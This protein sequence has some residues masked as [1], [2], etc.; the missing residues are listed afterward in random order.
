MFVYKTLKK[1]SVDYAQNIALEDPKRSINYQALHQ[2]SL[3]IAE[4]LRQKEAS[5]KKPVLVFIDRNIES[6]MAFYAVL[7]TGNFYVPIDIGQPETRVRLILDTL[8]PA[9]V[10]NAS[11]KKINYA[12]EELSVYDFNELEKAPEASNEEI[13]KIQSK[14]IDTD[15]MYAMFTSGSTGVPKGVLV[16]YRSVEDLV[17]Q[18]KKEFDFDQNNVFGNQAPFDFDVSVK[19][20]YNSLYVGG[21]VVIIPK[22]NFSF[23]KRLIQFLNEYKINTAIWATSVMRIVENLKGLEN[24]RP[25]YLDWVM[26]SG[27]IMPNKVLNYWRKHL[28]ET[29]FVN[30]YGPTEIT[31]NCSFYHVDRP[32]EDHEALPIGI[33][34]E[35]SRIVL[36]DE[37]NHL[38]KEAGKQGELCV[39]GSSLALGYY[40]N[41]EMTQEAFVQSP[42]NPYYPERMYRTGDLAYYNEEGLLM[43]ASRIDHQIKHMGHRIELGEIES[44]INALAYIEASVCI[45]DEEAE[46]IVL[47]YQAKEDYRKEIFKDMMTRVP[48]YMIPNTMIQFKTLPLNKN[49]K[50][51]RVLLE[52]EY[53]DGSYQ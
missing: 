29:N 20:I 6:L 50:I 5:F 51:D 12:M 30:L 3:N 18:F 37:N 7:Y 45:Y 17:K 4:F 28:P 26:F 39:L 38:I 36:L 46:K 53:L 2:T 47:F 22:V 44:H 19:D 14:M 43:F 40:N 24:D 33:P 27:E 8:K 23:P 9:Y 34:F 16:S 25:E 49:A 31:C 41:P 1:Q 15:P 13:E 42:L 52:K 11:G 35:N 48:K 32:Y 21:K 10:I